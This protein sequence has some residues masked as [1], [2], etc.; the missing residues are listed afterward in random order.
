MIYQ[1]PELFR[2]CEAEA[3]IHGWKLLFGFLDNADVATYTGPAYE[4]D[5]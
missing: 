1:K 4:V 5:E 3:A 2:L